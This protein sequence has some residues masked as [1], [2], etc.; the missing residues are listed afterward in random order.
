[1]VWSQESFHWLVNSVVIL[2]VICQLSRDVIG[3]EESTCDWCVSIA[4]YVWS[5]FCVASLKRTRINRDANIRTCIR[6]RAV[7]F[8]PDLN[9]VLNKIFLSRFMYL[10]GAYKNVFGLDSPK[11]FHRKVCKPCTGLKCQLMLVSNNAVTG[12]KANFIQAVKI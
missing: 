8:N 6:R 3:Y 1:M 2:L 5:V 11:M 7:E 9:R 10:V 12:F 4:I